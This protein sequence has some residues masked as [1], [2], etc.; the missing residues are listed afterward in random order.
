MA[1]ETFLMTQSR[2]VEIEGIGEVLFEPSRRAK[3]LNVSVRP[4]IGVRVAVPRRTSFKTA[5]DFV[6]SKTTWI[7]KH[8]KR[9]KE[10]EN[11]HQTLSKKVTD[12]DKD[13]ARR[14]LLERA[15]QLARLHGFAYSKVSVRN[16]KSRWGSCSHKN[17]ISLNMK[18]IVL[19]QELLDYVVLHELVHTRIKDHGSDFWKELDR[20]VGNARALNVKLE[21]YSM[22]LL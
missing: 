3:R 15:S 21:R 8:L 1:G 20:L 11:V 4:F 17:N 10:L 18:L 9:L 7:Q 13:E 2:T 6:S 5:R 14:T 12:I 16:L 19:P 22:V